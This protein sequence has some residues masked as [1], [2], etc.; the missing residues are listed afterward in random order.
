MGRTSKYAETRIMSRK[1]ISSSRETLT[2][3]EI[4]SRRKIICNT[5]NI[6]SDLLPLRRQHRRWRK[7]VSSGRPE[8]AKATTSKTMAILA[9]CRIVPLRLRGGRMLTRKRNKDF[10]RNQTLRLTPHNRL[11]TDLLT[12]PSARGGKNGGGVWLR[13]G[14]TRGD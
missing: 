8:R 1:N 11:A 9:G 7:A 3:V 5:R 14:R 4:R 2:R 13:R 10:N 6:T 12:S